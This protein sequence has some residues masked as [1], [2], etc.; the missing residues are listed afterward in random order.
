MMC[1][2][3]MF[4]CSMMLFMAKHILF[5]RTCCGIPDYYAVWSQHE[6]FGEVLV[7]PKMLSD[8]FP[9]AVLRAL[10]QLS[11]KH[12]TPR[13]PPPTSVVRT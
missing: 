13:T 3:A 2:L 9:D 10:E 7:S 8:H 4:F 11:D 12:F 6:E 1:C 5:S